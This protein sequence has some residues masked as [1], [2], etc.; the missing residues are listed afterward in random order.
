MCPRPGYL[1]GFNFVENWKLTR[2]AL[3]FKKWLLYWSLH[4]GIKMLR[5]QVN[6]LQLSL[7]TRRIF[8]SCKLRET[9]FLI[10]RNFKTLMKNIIK[11]TYILSII[12]FFTNFI[13]LF[14]QANAPI[15]YPVPY[16][17]HNLIMMIIKPNW[18]P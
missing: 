16:H 15:L 2:K 8:W 18:V 1:W 10:W 5:K 9:K 3:C 14:L 17:F 13:F 4:L 6:L 7:L 11:K 12:R